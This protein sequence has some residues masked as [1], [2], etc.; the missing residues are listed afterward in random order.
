[1]QKE[2]Y[3]KKIVTM[4]NLQYLPLATFHHER[5]LG[6]GPWGAAVPLFPGIYSKKHCNQPS[7]EGYSAIRV[8]FEFT[9]LNP[10]RS[11]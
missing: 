1:M 5:I 11:G 9:L 7:L 4:W 8:A 3:R 10:N 6:G 2:K